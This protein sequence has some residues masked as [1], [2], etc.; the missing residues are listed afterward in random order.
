MLILNVTVF[1]EQPLNS[2]DWDWYTNEAADLAKN[3]PVDQSKL[4][5]GQ[6]K[7]WGDESLEISKQYVYPGKFFSIR[8]L[9][10]E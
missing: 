4:E 6:F 7:T 8:S 10:S 9:K 2:T 3:H 5:A 1:A